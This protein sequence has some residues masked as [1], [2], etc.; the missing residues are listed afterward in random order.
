MKGTEMDVDGNAAHLRTLAGEPRPAGG[1]GEGRAR[2]D[3]AGVLRSA[4][5]EV[6]SEVF[7]YSSFPGRFATPVGGALGAATVLTAAGWALA[8]A[9]RFQPLLVLVIG[10]I[11]VG[12]FA[13]AMLGDA[14]LTLPWL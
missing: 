10:V 9:A 3:A 7:A 12:S 2:G 11:L 1:E 8:G 5:F 4:G 14:V 13:R 6:R